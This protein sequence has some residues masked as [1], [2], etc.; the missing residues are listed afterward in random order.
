M[1]NS[2]GK[3]KI[4]VEGNNSGLYLFIPTTTN[5]AI[6]HRFRLTTPKEY[7]VQILYG[8]VICK[9]KLIIGNTYDQIFTDK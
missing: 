8:Y 3:F 7:I 1:G 2:F 9:S 5:K 4:D 6:P